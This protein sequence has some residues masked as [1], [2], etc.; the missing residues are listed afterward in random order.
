MTTKLYAVYIMANARPTLYTG[1]TNDLVRRVHEH[2]AEVNSNCFTARYHLH[3]LVYFE[4]TDNPRSAIVREKQIKN[5]SRTQ[6]LALVKSVNP[7][8]R[9]LYPEICPEAVARQSPTL[10]DPGLRRDD[11]EPT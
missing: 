1:V 11:F 8:M 10:K 7:E 4:T 5:L 9:D 2:K 6:K 3:K